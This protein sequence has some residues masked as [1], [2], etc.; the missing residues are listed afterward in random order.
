MANLMQAYIEYLSD[1]VQFDQDQITD[2]PELVKVHLLLDHTITA[3][4]QI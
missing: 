2:I 4:K 3:H 1:S